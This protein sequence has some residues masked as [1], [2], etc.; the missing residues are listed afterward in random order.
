MNVSH[1]T[2]SSRWRDTLWNKLLIFSTN[3]TIFANWSGRSLFISV[4][5]CTWFCWG[6]ATA[7]LASQHPDSFWV[8][9][10]RWLP[11]WL[12]FSRQTIDGRVWWSKPTPTTHTPSCCSVTRQMRSC[13]SDYRAKVANA[14]SQTG[15]DNLV[16][17]AVRCQQSTTAT[18]APPDLRVP[19]V[20]V[21]DTGSAIASAQ[22]AR[23]PDSCPCCVL[24]GPEHPLTSNQK[25]ISRNVKGKSESTSSSRVG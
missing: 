21:C 13:S 10:P 20:Q 1:L 5:S 22:L 9:G 15:A 7:E 16:A 4:M 11:A 6:Q 17:Q 19:N 23:G 24:S 14:R 3:I 2:M 12:P 18:A 25:L 8:M